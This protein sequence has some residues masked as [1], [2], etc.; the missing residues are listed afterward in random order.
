MPLLVEKSCHYSIIMLYRNGAVSPVR[1]ELRLFDLSN[2]VREYQFK[3][4]GLK[5]SF[6]HTA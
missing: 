2:R 3:T 4:G 6:P 1:E 5:A